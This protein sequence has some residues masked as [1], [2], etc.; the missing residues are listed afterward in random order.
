MILPFASLV[1]KP[2]HGSLKQGQVCYTFEEVA[3]RTARYYERGFAVDRKRMVRSLGLGALPLLLVLFFHFW[4]IAVVVLIVVCAVLVQF[5]RKS[6]A[7]GAQF[8][9]DQSSLQAEPSG[10]RPSYALGSVCKS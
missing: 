9:G 2:K 10:E 6:S 8:S 4:V 1:F 7:V 3:T 5:M